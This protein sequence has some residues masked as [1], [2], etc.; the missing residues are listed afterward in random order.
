MISQS[1]ILCL[2]Y[3]CLLWRRLTGLTFH[4]HIKCFTVSIYIG[5]EKTDVDCLYLDINRATIHARPRVIGLGW[6]FDMDLY[7]LCQLFP[8]SKLS[9]GMF[10][11]LWSVLLLLLKWRQWR[12]IS[13]QINWRWK[14]KQIFRFYPILWLRIITLFQI[15]LWVTVVI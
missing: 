11:L 10:G 13:N 5:V 4:V 8:P 2:F 6:E 9:V 1:N 3:L 15:K 12:S 7:C 14:I